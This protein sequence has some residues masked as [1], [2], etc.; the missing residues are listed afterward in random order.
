MHRFGCNP[1]TGSIRCVLRV[2]CI[3]YC[4]AIITFSLYA[5]YCILELLLPLYACWT[6]FAILVFLYLN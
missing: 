3:V 4:L 1:P 2:Y 6:L 5:L